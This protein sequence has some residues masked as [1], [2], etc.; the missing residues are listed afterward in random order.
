[1]VTAQPAVRSLCIK[2][3]CSPLQLPDGITNVNVNSCGY[4]INSDWPYTNRSPEKFFMAFCVQMPKA[5]YSEPD[6]TYICA[7]KTDYNP[8]DNSPIS[9]S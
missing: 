7:G 9:K 8:F 6:E 1:M 2:E 4:C 5:K 3:Y